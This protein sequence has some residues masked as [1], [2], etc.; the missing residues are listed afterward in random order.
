VTTQVVLRLRADAGQA[1]FE[2]EDQGPGIAPADLQQ[3]TQRF[4]R[5]G[6]QAGCGLGLAIVQAIVQRCAGR[7]EFDNRQDGLS[8]LLQLPLRTFA[9]ISPA[10]TGPGMIAQDAEARARSQPH[11]L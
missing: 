2:V 11:E 4:W 9:P 3:L 5:S 6:P 1:L 10:A 7:L 8:V